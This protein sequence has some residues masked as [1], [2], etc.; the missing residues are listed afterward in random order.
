MPIAL[1]PI[2]L[3]V[4]GAYETGLGMIPGL[5][6]TGSELTE[7]YN[8]PCHNDTIHAGHIIQSIH[9]GRCGLA[10]TRSTIH[11]MWILDPSTGWSFISR[12]ASAP[13]QA[14]VAS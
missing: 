13:R 2:I 5:P 14:L 12:P 6:T 7:I 11:A 8:G 9:L 10:L 3:L 4:F 1:Y